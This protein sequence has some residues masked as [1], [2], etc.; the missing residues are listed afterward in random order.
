M[1]TRYKTR[2]SL[3]G[4]GEYISIGN[5]GQVPLIVVVGVVGVAPPLARVDRPWISSRGM[6]YGVHWYVCRRV[7]WFLIL[8]FS[9]EEQKVSPR[10]KEDDDITEPA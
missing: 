1:N 4:I 2:P 8:R 7:G 9:A 10:E 3:S 5:W 6:V